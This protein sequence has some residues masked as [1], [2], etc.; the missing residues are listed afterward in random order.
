M[1]MRSLAVA[2]GLVGVLGAR[3]EPAS[4]LVASRGIAASAHV[5]RSV[6]RH[7]AHRARDAGPA[8]TRTGDG[9]RCH[10]RRGERSRAPIRDLCLGPWRCGRPP[11]SGCGRGGASRPLRSVPGAPGLVGCGARRIAVN[12][13]RRAV[14][15]PRCHARRSRRSGDPRR[16]R[17]RWMERRGPLRS[18]AHPWDLEADSTGFPAHGRTAIPERDP[19]HH[20]E[21]GTVLARTASGPHG[22]GL[23]ARL[24]R[25]EIH[26]TGYECHAD[27]RP[28]AHRAFLVRGSVPTPGAAS[29]ASFSR[30]TR[31]TCT[32]PRGC[33]RW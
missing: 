29:P 5:I 6:V 32:K 26:R 28:D 7:G 3:G 27:G 2:L 19:V 16:T 18:R 21:Q 31:S 25:G 17:K 30:T 10:A 23:S 13:S 1:L 15:T 22:A 4:G 12:Y 9:A 33:T 14:Q 11:G 24:R 20:R 8:L